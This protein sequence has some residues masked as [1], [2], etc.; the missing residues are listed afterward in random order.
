M[1]KDEPIEKEELTEEEIKAEAIINR[2][3][4]PVESEKN[5]LIIIY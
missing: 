4:E 2:Y 1:K 5:Q 3:L